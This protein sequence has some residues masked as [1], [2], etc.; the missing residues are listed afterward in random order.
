MR[1]TLHWAMVV[2]FVLCLAVSSEARNKGPKIKVTQPSVDG[3]VVEGTAPLDITVLFSERT[4]A[5]DQESL[6]I[7]VRISKKPERVWAD[8]TEHF[9]TNCNPKW[10]KTNG[11]HKL[12]MSSCPIPAGIHRVRIIIADVD[13]KKTSKR[14]Y[15]DID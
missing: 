13:G 6:K 7:K 11:D 2:L 5:V 3:K 9:R 12:E 15:F 1:A 4:A 8:I 14:Y 10:T